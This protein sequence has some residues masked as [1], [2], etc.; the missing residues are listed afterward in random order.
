MFTFKPIYTKLKN[1]L[2]IFKSLKHFSIDLA[3]MEE[4]GNK[5]TNKLSDIYGF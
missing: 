5:Q 2:Y 3:I 4:L 1:V